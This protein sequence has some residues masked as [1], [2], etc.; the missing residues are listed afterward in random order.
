V[1]ESWEGEMAWGRPG[2]YEVWEEF[3]VRCGR[4]VR[5]RFDRWGCRHLGSIGEGPLFDYV[6]V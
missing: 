4:F 6:L 3:E 1:E 5:R 2:G